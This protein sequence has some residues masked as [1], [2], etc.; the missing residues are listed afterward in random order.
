MTKREVGQDWFYFIGLTHSLTHSKR[1]LHDWHSK[2]VGDACLHFISGGTDYFVRRIPRSF[3]LRTVISRRAS[4]RAKNKPNP[5]LKYGRFN[6]KWDGVP[7][8]SVRP[9]RTLGWKTRRGPLLLLLHSIQSL[10][11]KDVNDLP[12]FQVKKQW[13]NSEASLFSKSSM[14]AKFRVIISNVGITKNQ[15]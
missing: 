2:S 14:Q 3:Y 10:G 5:A 4:P 7:Q 11:L 9:P 15:Q 1:M 6:L 8:C 12:R 13:E